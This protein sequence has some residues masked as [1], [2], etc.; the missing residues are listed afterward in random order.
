[1]D[2]TLQLIQSVQTNDVEN[3]NRLIRAGADINFIDENGKSL[4]YYAFAAD[5]TDQ[6]KTLMGNGIDLNARDMNG[7]TQFYK[8][9]DC[10]DYD[11][12]SFLISIGAN[13]NITNNDGKTPVMSL[14]KPITSYAICRSFML[15]VVHSAPCVNYGIQDVLGNTVLMYATDNPECL[16]IILY[17]NKDLD[18]KN[19]RGET[20][21][22]LAVK[23]M[24]YV[25]VEALLVA[26]AD[27]N[28]RDAEDDTALIVACK[29]QLI[30][31]VRLIA[32]YVKTNVDARNKLGMT[33]LMYAS[34]NSNIPIIK[35]LKSRN[36]NPDLKDVDSRTAVDHAELMLV[37]K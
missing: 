19:L 29:K 30:E 16:P 13:I 32:S 34:I 6:I 18:V 15:L 8:A 5:Q 2:L 36:A 28:V 9:C 17:Q 23:N 12:A 31:I 10:Y 20:A 27:P 14:F 22:M 3:T 26:G 35:I 37:D 1:M 24:N 25:S 21:L 33:A 11:Y 7:E 4:L